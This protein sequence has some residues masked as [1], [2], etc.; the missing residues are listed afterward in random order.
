[1]LFNLENNHEQF[2]KNIGKIG[3]FNERNKSIPMQIVLDNGAISDDV[4][5]VLLKWRHDFG[6]LLNAGGGAIVAERFD[7]VK[8]VS[9]ADLDLDID[10]IEVAK[11][12]ENAKIGKAAGIDLIPSDVLKNEASLFVLH[13]LFNVCFQ[14]GRIPSLWSKSIIN[15]IPKSSSNDLRDP[16]SYRGISLASTIYKMYTSI[17]NERIVKWTDAKEIIVDEQNGFRKKRSTIDHL[18][19]LT[20]IIDTRTKNRQ[21]TFCAFIDFK[22]SF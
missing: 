15:P 19:S 20:N 1:M 6:N 17:L 8:N 16:M 11:A 22:K 18:S 12:M 5:M 4:K 2:W 10:I 7:G 14:T 3:I 21:S 13:S 9:D